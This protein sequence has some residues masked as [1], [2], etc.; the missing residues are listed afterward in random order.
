MAINN[1]NHGKRGVLRVYTKDT[2]IIT[3]KDIIGNGPLLI[4]SQLNVLFA[5]KGPE[6]FGS[7]VDKSSTHRCV[8]QTL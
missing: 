3:A 7:N 6:V 5:M 8:M 1:F 4:A 2:L